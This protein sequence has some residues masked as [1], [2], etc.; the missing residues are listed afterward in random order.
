MSNSP[1][2]GIY[3]E[4]LLFSINCGNNPRIYKIR[5]ECNS[6]APYS[7]DRLYFSKS[8]S[9]ELKDFNKRTHKI[10]CKYSQEHGIMHDCR[11]KVFKYEYR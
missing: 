10:E 2:Y 1:I 8:N 7:S 3:K 6:I 11:T 4:N 5:N 9:T